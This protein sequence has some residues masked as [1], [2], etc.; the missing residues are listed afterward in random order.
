MAVILNFLR[1]VLVGATYG[2]GA[3]V[4]FSLI[5]YYLLNTLSESAWSEFDSRGS[6]HL[7]ITESEKVIRNSEFAILGEFKNTGEKQI[8]GISIQADI[9]NSEGKFIEQCS[10]DIKGAVLPK[11]K[12]H[13]KISCESAKEILENEN[14][15]Y[16]LR[17]SAI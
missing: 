17:I 14:S 2:L 16:S 6:S 1:R 10:K 5:T 4:A 3:G 9:L 13:F 7:E 8:R 15:K 12:I 11:Q